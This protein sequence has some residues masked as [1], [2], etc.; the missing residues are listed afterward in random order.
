MES[1]SSKVPGSGSGKSSPGVDKAAEEAAKKK[2]PLMSK[3]MICKLLAEF[4]R[5]YAGCAKLV[6]E[7]HYV[8][9]TNERITEVN[10]GLGQAFNRGRTSLILRECMSCT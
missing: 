5:S 8:T 2:K 4:V 10:I 7:H 1:E 6:T 9:G 3:A